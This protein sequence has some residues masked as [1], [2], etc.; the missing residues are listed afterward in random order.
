MF[1][2]QINDIKWGTDLQYGVDEYLM[3]CQEAC[4]SE[5][6]EFETLSG[7]PFCG[8]STCYWREVLFYL[9]PKIIQGNID[10]KVELAGE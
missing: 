2:F 1:E 5:D 6:D 8:C 9:T 7:E 3:Q 10:G 4:D